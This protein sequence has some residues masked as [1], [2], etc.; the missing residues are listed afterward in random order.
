MRGPRPIKAIRLRSTGPK[1]KPANRGRGEIQF[2]TGWPPKPALSLWKT[3][4]TTQ[5]P[6]RLS[7]QITTPELP[8]S[9][10][11]CFGLHRWCGPCV[12]PA[13][14]RQISFQIQAEIL[15]DRRYEYETGDDTVQKPQRAVYHL[16]HARVR[17]LA[18][19]RDLIEPS[20]FSPPETT[21]KIER[22]RRRPRCATRAC[23]KEYGKLQALS[24]LVVSRPNK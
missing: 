8:W 13:P 7:S 15:S 5:H 14:L 6:K 4:K 21:K 11:W 9:A 17:G 1:P 18:L 2:G 12:V 24:L 10:S 3:S 23:R 22:A 16:V 19:P 20:R